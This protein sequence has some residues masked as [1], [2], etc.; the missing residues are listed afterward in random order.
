LFC[1]CCSCCFCFC[2]IVVVVVVVVVVL[3]VVGGGGGGGGL[4]V[5]DNRVWCIEV[6]ARVTAK[7]RHA[8][9]D[10]DNGKSNSNLFYSLFYNKDSSINRHFPAV[11]R[12]GSRFLFS[13]V[14]AAW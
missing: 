3:V 10:L 4:V 2:F 9:V 11:A 13:V 1:C 8:G 6:S 7:V 14:E 12:C 5:V